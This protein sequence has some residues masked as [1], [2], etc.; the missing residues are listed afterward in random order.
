MYLR[1]FGIGLLELHGLGQRC[2]AF[3][4]FGCQY[5]CSRTNA[6]PRMFGYFDY[7]FFRTGE[8]SFLEI[9]P[10]IVQFILFINSPFCIG[11]YGDFELLL[12]LIDGKPLTVHWCFRCQQHAVLCAFHFHGNF[13]VAV[14]NG[15]YTRSH[16]TCVGGSFY[17]NLSVLLAFNLPVVTSDRKP[18]VT[19]CH[20]STPLLVTEHIECHSIAFLVNHLYVLYIQIGSTFLS[21]YKAFA[22]PIVTL[23]VN[24]IY[25][26]VQCGIL[27]AGNSYS[28]GLTSFTR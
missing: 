10:C 4:G 22:C 25:T 17:C 23:D 28:I 2:S 27:F 3:G 1:T 12:L 8:R 18:D 15:Y 6:G 14:V 26:V 11:F 16:F 20:L 21:E 24:G 13:S 5:D 7:Q 19:F 9:V